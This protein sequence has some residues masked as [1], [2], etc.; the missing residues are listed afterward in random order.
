MIGIQIFTENL[1]ETFS[2][3]Q[4]AFGAAFIGDAWGDEGELIHLEMDIMGSRIALAPQLPH[5]INKRDNVTVLCLKFKEK[6]ALLNAYNTLMEGG[7]TD[8]LKEY[9][10]SPLEGYITDKYGVVWCVGI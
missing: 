1:P 9:P 5:R 7:H 10:W 8:G 2:L 4:R 3:Y 6:E